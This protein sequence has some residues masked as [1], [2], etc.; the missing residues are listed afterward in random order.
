MKYDE[1]LPVGRTFPQ[2][3]GLRGREKRRDHRPER[4]DAPLFRPVL[5][6]P[7]GAELLLTYEGK[8]SENV[9]I[10]GRQLFG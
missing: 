5:Y 1:F 10:L 4:F 7:K 9:I 8:L 3:G 2:L 6:E